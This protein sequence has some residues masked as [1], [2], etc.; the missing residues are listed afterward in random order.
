MRA[1]QKLE[2]LPD[3]HQQGALTAGPRNLIAA[4]IWSLIHRVSSAPSTALE[5][6]VYRTGKTLPLKEKEGNK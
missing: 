2:S 1:A 6:V 5:H 3:T 4:A